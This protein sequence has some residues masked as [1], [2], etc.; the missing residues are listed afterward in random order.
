MKKYVQ[1]SS[2]VTIRVNPGLYNIDST[3]LRSP[4][5]DRLSVKPMWTRFRVLLQ[6]SRT[7]YPAE[8]QNWDSVKSL[9]AN[10]KVIVGMESDTCD[11]PRAE[12]DYQMLANARSR[13]NAEVKRNNEILGVD[14]V[15]AKQVVD[16]T[17]GNAVKEEA[18]KPKRGRKKKS[19]SAV[20]TEQAEE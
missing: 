5:A 7:W 6:P 18:P 19:E 14:A 20:P 12:K 13:Y 3:N 9:V 17:Y 11:D 1:L 10:G 2:K 4:V 16:D 8:I 15:T